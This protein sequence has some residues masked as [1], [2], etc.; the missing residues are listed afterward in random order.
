MDVELGFGR[1]GQALFE[2]RLSGSSMH[3]EREPPKGSIIAVCN[4]L[5][6]SVIVGDLRSVEHQDTGVMLAVERRNRPRTA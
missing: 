2:K 5:E 1:S 3:H 4:P 6:R